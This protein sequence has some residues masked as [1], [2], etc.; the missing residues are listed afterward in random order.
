[1]VVTGNGI[2]PG[3]SKLETPSSQRSMPPIANLLWPF[4]CLFVWFRLFIPSYGENFVDETQDKWMGIVEIS[5]LKRTSGEGEVDKDELL[6][7][8]CKEAQQ[9]WKGSDTRLYIG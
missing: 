5:V 9:C 1:M 6:R 4:W 8:R 7:S 2:G 3:V